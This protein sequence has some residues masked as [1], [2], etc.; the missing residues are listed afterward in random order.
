M[1]WDPST[2][3]QLSAPGFN[4][5]IGAGDVV[6]YWGAQPNQGG[7]SGAGA[8]E[9]GASYDPG[10]MGG[11]TGSI[12]VDGGGSALNNLSALTPILNQIV[13]QQQQDSIVSGQGNAQANPLPG[14]TPGLGS[15]DVAAQAQAQS[16]GLP[17]ASA[18]GVPGIAPPAGGSTP[19]GAPGA[20][21][22]GAPGGVGAPGDAG[23]TGGS[24]DSAG[25]PGDAGAAAGDAAG[26]PGAPGTPGGADGPAAGDAG[27]AGGAGGAGSSV[28]CSE[29]R[30]QGYLSAT[31]WAAD[32]AF[33]RAQSRATRDGYWLWAAPIARGMVRSRV[34][35]VVVAALAIPWALE[36]AYQMGVRERGNRLGR[37]VMAIG[38]PLCKFLGE[39]YPK[40]VHA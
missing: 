39:K 14:A 29:L 9:P 10:A 16:G 8:A 2:L 15:A 24:G 25:A 36:M 32:E 13:Q 37:V 34:L 5:A 7:A 21:A 33:G 18:G 30:R 38:L 28:I 20:D 17:I 27:G 22:G 12:G 6:P 35:T 26:G 4:R 3:A 19:S 1:I 40:G 23:A 31:I 11:P